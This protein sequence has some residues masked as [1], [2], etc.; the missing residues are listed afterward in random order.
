M[1]T[2]EIWCVCVCTHWRGN[3]I[4]CRRAARVN[5]L[6]LSPECQHNPHDIL[7][8]FILLRRVFFF[9]V[10]FCSFSFHSPSV[11][12]IGL[13]MI[14]CEPTDSEAIPLTEIITMI[15]PFVLLV[16]M[17]SNAFDSFTIY[18][19]RDSE[20]NR[21]PMQMEHTHAHALDSVGQR[22]GSTYCTKN[23]PILI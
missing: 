15:S 18:R 6:K 17:H 4:G 16:L 23:C 21:M 19:F 13:G 11:R 14:R 12:Q 5:L 10:A 3:S 2:N 1:Q 9:V 22:I 7:V 20:Q 8:T